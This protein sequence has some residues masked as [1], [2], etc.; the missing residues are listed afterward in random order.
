MKN[1]T[2]LRKIVNIYENEIKSGLQPF[3]GKYF[4]NVLLLDL[5]LDE[6]Y[7]AIMLAR[8]FR[9]LYDQIVAEVQEDIL[10]AFNLSLEELEIVHKTFLARLF[11]NAKEET[12]RGKKRLQMFRELSKLNIAEADGR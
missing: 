2:E 3:F 7:E 11:A 12:L 6:K 10:L 5:F 4:L 9:K 8:K 1:K